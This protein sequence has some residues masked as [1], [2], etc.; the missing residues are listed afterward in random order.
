MGPDISQSYIK[1]LLVLEPCQVCASW[2]SLQRNCENMSLYHFEELICHPGFFNLWEH[3]HFQIVCF[4][5][6]LC[7]R[8]VTRFDVPVALT[9]GKNNVQ[10]TQ[11]LTMP[12][13]PGH[14]AQWSFAVTRGVTAFQPIT[15][16]DVD[17]VWHG[18]HLGC[19]LLNFPPKSQ[20][21]LTLH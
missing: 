21:A 5:T 10:A 11:A 9:T 19:R 6:P 1:V 20:R 7:K 18:N 4:I 2:S 13:G 12:E 3:N 16:A 8:D 17:V 15:V 14:A